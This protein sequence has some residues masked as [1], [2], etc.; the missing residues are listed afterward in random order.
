MKSVSGWA[1]LST[2]YLAELIER[3]K[4]LAPMHWL[5]KAILIGGRFAA[6]TCDVV[7]RILLET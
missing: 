3:T 6:S 2:S 1:P 4:P 5:D 7:R